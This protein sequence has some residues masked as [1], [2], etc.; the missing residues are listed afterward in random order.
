MPCHGHVNTSLGRDDK[1]FHGR[2]AS[3]GGTGQ[4]A[5]ALRWRASNHSATRIIGQTPPA[6]GAWL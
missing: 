1:I 6:L 4:V 3:A 2:Y 5:P